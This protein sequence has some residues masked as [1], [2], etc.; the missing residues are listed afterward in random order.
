MEYCHVK[1]I[2]KDEASLER[3]SR[4]FDLLKKEKDSSEK[5]NEESLSE[6]L[7]AEEKSHFWWPSDAEQKEWQS[8]WSSTSVEVRLS[9]KMP[10]PPWDLESMYEALWNGDY[11][12]ISVS[13]ET[14]GY[15][16]NFYPHGYP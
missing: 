12:L 6:F 14:E 10:M 11:D 3:L 13:K 16:L 4:F 15:H 7:S 8:F 1:F 9:P 2:P 5:P